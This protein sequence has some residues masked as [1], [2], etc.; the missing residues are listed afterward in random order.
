[1]KS[2]AYI[3]CFADNINSSNANAFV[4]SRKEN[5][6]CMG[7]FL[8]DKVGPITARNTDIYKLPNSYTLVWRRH[9]TENFLLLWLSPFRGGF[10]DFCRVFLFIFQ[11]GRLY[12]RW[13]NRYPVDESLYPAD[14]FYSERKSRCTGKRY[15]TDKNALSVRYIY[16]RFVGGLNP[17]SGG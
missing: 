6:F 2:N 3:T 12:E 11:L 15:P 8:E 1:M 5:I 9:L 17:L 16:P 7:R 13:I 10:S 14:K 4:F